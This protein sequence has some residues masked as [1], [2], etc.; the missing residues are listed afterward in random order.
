MDDRDKIIIAVVFGIVGA[1]SIIVIICLI[2]WFIVRHK[3]NSKN[4]TKNPSIPHRQQYERSQN[5]SLTKYNSNKQRKRKRRFNTND[6]AISFSFNPPHLINQNVKNL[7]KLA[8]LES[9]FTTNLWHPEDT[10]PAGK[11][12]NFD[13][14][15]I[16][17]TSEAAHIPS[18]LSTSISHPI[19]DL[20]CYQQLNALQFHFLNELNRGIVTRQGQPPMNPIKYSQSCRQ[21]TDL[22]PFDYFRSIT[23]SIILTNDDSLEKNP[24]QTPKY[25]NATLMRRAHLAKLRDDTAIL[26]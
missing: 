15:Y 8:P 22:L 17:S 26:Y 25:S 10:S 18:S 2:I 12:D 23:S 24:I 7:D 4:H 21:P 9:S 19:K 11:V 14:C 6:S 20:Q 13:R 16:N 3:S 5:I 1:I